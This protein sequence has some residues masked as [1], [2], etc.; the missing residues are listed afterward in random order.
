[1]NYLRSDIEGLLEAVIKL[2]KNIY[3]KYQLNITKFKTL[4][5]LSLV[6]YISSY[7]PGNLKPELKMIK[8]EIEREIR[9]SYFG[10]NVD[11]FVNEIDNGYLYDVNSQY[12][13]AML[14][15]MPVGDPVLSLET[16]LDIYLALFM[17]K[18]F[19]QMKLF[20]EFL[21]FNT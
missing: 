4:P 9:S 1:M 3:D 10:G 13:K 14:F 18:S 15:D 21:L 7:L 11:V 2:Y 19:V 20:Y 6:S 16:N 17:V 5:G 12:G 8:G